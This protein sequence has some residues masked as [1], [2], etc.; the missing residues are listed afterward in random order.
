MKRIRLFFTVMVMLLASASAFAQ[1]MTVSGVVTDSA[2]APV[3]GATVMVEGTQTGTSTDADGAFKITAPANGKLI[4]SIIGYAT[5]TVPVEGL[6]Q[7]VPSC[8]SKILS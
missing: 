8:A 5:Q 7:G 6:H 1:N 2:D 3:P 4:V